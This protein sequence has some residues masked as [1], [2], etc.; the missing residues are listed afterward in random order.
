MD[1]IF[2]NWTVQKCCSYTLELK[3]NF[4]FLRKKHD[5]KST[6]DLREEYYFQTIFRPDKFNSQSYEYNYFPFQSRFCNPNCFL[7]TVKVEE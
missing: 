6:I 4:Y 2:L 1:E 7:F 3:S 5:L